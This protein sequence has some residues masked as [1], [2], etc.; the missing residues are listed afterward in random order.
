MLS[1][2]KLF[3]SFHNVSSKFTE[4]IVILICACA[5]TRQ[6]SRGPKRIR[7]WLRIAI[8]ARGWAYTTLNKAYFCVSVSLFCLEH[9]LHD[10]DPAIWRAFCEGRLLNILRIHHLTR[11]NP[12]FYALVTAYCF[13]GLSHF[14]SKR[15][16]QWYILLKCFI[17]RIFR[18]H[19]WGRQYRPPS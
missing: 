7:W 11:R 2:I 13:S 4:E 14:H 17:Y 19:L 6:N 16:K 8:S 15:Y 3:H 5:T 10:S 18:R 1:S 12:T 9:Y